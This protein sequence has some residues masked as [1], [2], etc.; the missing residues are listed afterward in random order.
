[1]ADEPTKI[2]RTGL[3][4]GGPCDGTTLTS[5]TQR[6]VIPMMVAGAPHPGIYEWCADHWFFVGVQHAEDF[7]GRVFNPPSG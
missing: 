5:D 3:A 7:F 1:M 4:V 6:I 2:D